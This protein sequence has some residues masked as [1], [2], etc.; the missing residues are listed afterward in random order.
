MKIDSCF[1]I[2]LYIDF[3]Y[4]YAILAILS[5]KIYNARYVF[6]IQHTEFSF[7][8]VWIGFFNLHASENGRFVPEIKP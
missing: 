2:L 6:Y 4:T 5:K 1:D 7:I 3:T 8:N